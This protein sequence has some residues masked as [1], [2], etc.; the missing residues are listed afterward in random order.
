MFAWL[1]K[2][3]N[4]G[5]VKEPKVVAHEPPKPAPVR[6]EEYLMRKAR[7]QARIRRAQDDFNKSGYGNG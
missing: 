6:Y 5:A 7:Q 4:R 2:L 3:R 1:R